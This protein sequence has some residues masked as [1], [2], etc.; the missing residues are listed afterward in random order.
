MQGLPPFSCPGGEEFVPSP[1]EDRRGRRATRRRRGA[2]AGGTSDG[3]HGRPLGGSGHRQHR[4]GLRR[5]A[6]GGSLR[7]GGRGRVRGQGGRSQSDAKR[8]GGDLE[9]HRR[10]ASSRDRRLT[11]VGMRSAGRRRTASARRPAA[12][13]GILGGRLLSPRTRID[14][15]TV[16]RMLPLPSRRQSSNIS[17]KWSRRRTRMRQA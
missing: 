3:G 16:R 9:E 17:M 13:P 8:P 5:R 7:P 10:G 2:C 11:A 6:G 4:D 14:D 15:E 12:H 1:S